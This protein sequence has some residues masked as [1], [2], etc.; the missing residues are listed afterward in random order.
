[1][2]IFQMVGRI[3]RGTPVVSISWSDKNGKKEVVRYF[4]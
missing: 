1:M 4:K 2:A 3:V